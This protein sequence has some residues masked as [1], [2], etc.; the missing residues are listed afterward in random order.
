MYVLRFMT[1]HIN[2]IINLSAESKKS[3]QYENSDLKF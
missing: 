3:Y 1:Q 2:W